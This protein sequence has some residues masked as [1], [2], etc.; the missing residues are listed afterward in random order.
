MVDEPNPWSG[1]TEQAE[2]N[3][4]KIWDWIIGRKRRTLREWL[5]D[6]RKRRRQNLHYREPEVTETEIYDEMVDRDKI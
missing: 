2:V 6:N 4:I 3:L 5:A 1:R